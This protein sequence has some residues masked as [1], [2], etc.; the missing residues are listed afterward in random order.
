M[1]TGTIVLTGANGTLG[2]AYVRSA[3]KDFPE[4][5]A[6]L[7]VRNDGPSDPNT[8]KLR[9]IIAAFPN[10]KYSIHTLDLSSLAS[11]RVFSSTIAGKVASGE[12]PA[13]STIVCNA[14]AWSISTGLKFTG[15]GYELSLQVNHLSHFA[16]ILQLLGSIDTSNGRIV[17]LSSDSHYPG[18]SGLEQFPPTFPEDIEKLAKP[19]KDAPG[20]EVGRGFQRYGLSKLCIVMFAYELTRRLQEV[21][22]GSSSKGFEF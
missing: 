11:V 3:L 21:R 5:H 1:S 14:F 18:K 15:D 22:R 9:E 8:A 13:I 12:L 7:T 19:A 10:A 17:V 20:E 4:Y 16:L 2:L 6:V